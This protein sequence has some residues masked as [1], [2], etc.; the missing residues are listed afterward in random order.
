MI[1]LRVGTRGSQLALTQTDLVIAALRT[2][3]PELLVE[4]VIVRTEGD[5]RRRASLLAIGGQGIFTRELEIALLDD[6]IDVAV[7]SLKDLPSTLPDGLL[8]AVTPPRDDARDVLVTRDG[9]TLIRLP[10]RASIGTGSLR[11]RAQMLA[12][13][14]DLVMKDIRGNVDTRLAKLDRGEY[15]G[16][17]LAAAGLRRLG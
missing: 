16:V 13:R 7:H 9:A 5:R 12:Q 8:L 2:A 3:R 14:P 6:E 4:R 11:R 17:I 1:R 15:D 10:D